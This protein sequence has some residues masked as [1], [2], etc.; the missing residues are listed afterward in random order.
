[1]MK[2]FRKYFWFCSFLSSIFMMAGFPLHAIWG[3]L[4]VIFSVLLGILEV[5]VEK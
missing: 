1:M 5:L 4:F 2:N 3:I